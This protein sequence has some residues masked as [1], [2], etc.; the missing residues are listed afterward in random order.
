MWQL[1]EQ[2][3]PEVR[4]VIGPPIFSLKFSWPCLPPW[5]DFILTLGSLMEAKMAVA[6]SGLM[7]THHGIHS[8]HFLSLHSKGRYQNSLI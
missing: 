5:V 6:V 3:N 2:F 1:Q 8:Q 7:Y 4:D